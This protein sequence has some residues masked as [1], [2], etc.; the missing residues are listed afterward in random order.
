MRAKHFIVFIIISLNLVGLAVASKDSTNNLRFSVKSDFMSQHLWRGYAMCKVPSVEPSAELSYKSFKAG[1]WAALSVDGKYFE[2][3]TY[4][5]YSYKGFSFGIYDYYCP[6]ELKSAQQYFNYRQFTTKHTID[7]HLEYEGNTSFPFK[8][9]LATMVY[10]DDY[11]N[12]TKK[13]YY[14]TYFEAGY[15]TV[16]N[17]SRLDYFVGFN[18][19]ESYYGEKAA[20]VNTGIKASG[21]VQLFNEKNVPIQASIIYNPLKSSIYMVF[22]LTIH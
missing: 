13:K 10:G 12:F 1:I 15:F 17:A 21:N 20:L 16:F 9:L 2:I 6:G 18:L 5:K 22:G 4:L 19:F 3:D 7:L 11:D 14:S 8:A